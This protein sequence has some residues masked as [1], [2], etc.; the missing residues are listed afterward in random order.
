MGGCTAETT[1]LREMTEIN[2]TFAR[3]LNTDTDIIDSI[4]TN[5]A[6]KLW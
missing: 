1:C 4:Q 5:D 3:I 2:K 6:T